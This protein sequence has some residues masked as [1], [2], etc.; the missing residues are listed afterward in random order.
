MEIWA[1][2]TLNMKN[3]NKVDGRTK[4]SKRFR[5][6]VEDIVRLVGDRQPPEVV[7]R[8]A[9]TFA[10]LAIRQDQHI[11]RLLDGRPM[12]SAGYVRLVNASNRVLRHLGLIPADENG[13][14]MADG[15]FALE[16]YVAG[17][18]SGNG[19]RRDR[20]RSRLVD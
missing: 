18:R 12:D 8:L 15:Q 1:E 10:A 9:R 14:D 6:I 17:K 7:D 3:A 16:K 20:R 13:D 2:K 19:T 11:A 5:A 4:E